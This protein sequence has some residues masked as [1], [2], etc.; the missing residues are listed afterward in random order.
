MN[1]Y[2]VLYLI[3]LQKLQAQGNTAVGLLANNY[4]REDF[5]ESECQQ[6][7]E[8]YKGRKRALPQ[9]IDNSPPI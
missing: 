7:V 5:F 1:M 3:H 9:R 2:S 6:Q 8:D 4:R